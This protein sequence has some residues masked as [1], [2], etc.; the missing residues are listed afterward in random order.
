M[1]VVIGKCWQVDKSS[2]VDVLVP[3]QGWQPRPSWQNI[4]RW[5]RKKD[6]VERSI[7]QLSPIESSGRYL[8]NVSSQSW[9]SNLLKLQSH[10]GYP[11]DFN[12]KGKHEN[13]QLRL[14][15]RQSYG[16]SWLQLTMTEG[17]NSRNPGNG[18]SRIIFYPEETTCIGR[19]RWKGKWDSLNVRLQL[20]SALIRRISSWFIY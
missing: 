17:S 6:N 4:V 15:E 14:S 7:V 2:G 19:H 20:L 11:S 16:L 12:E 3:Y 18:R 10:V 1:S 9:F 13:P 5:V 8:Q